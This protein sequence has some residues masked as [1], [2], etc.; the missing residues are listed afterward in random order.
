MAELYNGARALKP[1]SE[2][3]A[4]RKAILKMKA[5]RSGELKSLKSSW[6][7]FNDAFC[8]GLEWRTITVV[9]AR[10][11]TGKTLFMEQLISDII[12]ENKDHKF[13]VLKF[14]FEMLDE[15]NGIRKLSLNTASDYNTLM[16]KGEPVDKDLY[17]KCIQYYE[18]TAETDVID[19]V[20][21]PCTVDEMCATIHYYMEAH[22]DEDGNYT[23]AL[24]TIDH[25]ALLKV[26][27]GQRD[28][29]EVLYALGE[30][31]TYMKKHY[32]VAFLVLSQLNRNIDNPDRSKDGDYGNYVLDSDLFGADAL[33]QHAD[34]VLGI[35]KPAI[36]KIRFYGPERFI[37]ND[38]DLL[39]FHFLKSR[40]GTTRLSFFKLDR[41][42]MRI[43]EIETPPQA[44]KLKL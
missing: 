1:V 14:Q 23:N 6:P 10:P 22:K 28:K 12:E 41:E 40:N 31:L 16:S 3:D 29:F 43:V 24:V 19:V 33:L 39:A 30:A 8:D 35:N 15:T 11:G 18:Q 13:R 25:S 44:T 38:E 32:P 20:Y 7:K 36:R 26:G 42:N 37:V 17:L 27:K 9:G 21:D 2:R 5:R 4:L 34:V